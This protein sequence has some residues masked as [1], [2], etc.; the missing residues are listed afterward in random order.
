MSKAHVRNVEIHII[1]FRWISYA[2]F[3]VSLIQIEILVTI[4]YRRGTLNKL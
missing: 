4:F 1:I 2:A 3:A